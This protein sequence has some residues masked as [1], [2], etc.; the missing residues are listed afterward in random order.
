MFN[1]QH[2]T[3]KWGRC[4]SVGARLSEAS[5][6]PPRRKNAFGQYMP[7]GYLADS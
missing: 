1:T 3:S 2:P 7:V 4:Q 5:V 6:L